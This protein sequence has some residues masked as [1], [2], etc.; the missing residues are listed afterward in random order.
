M[1]E[2][3][4]KPTDTPYRFGLK[5]DRIIKEELPV[6]KQD[7]FVTQYQSLLGCLNWL[8][9]NTQPDVNM[10]YG[11]LSQFNSEPSPGH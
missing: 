6:S 8:T 5:M 9:I 1:L 10:A 11:L 7:A 2:N 4:K 3:I